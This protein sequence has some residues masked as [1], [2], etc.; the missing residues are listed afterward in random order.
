MDSH[1]SHL[2]IEALDL[3]KATDITVLSLIH[4]PRSDYSSEILVSMLQS[5]PIVMPKLSF[6]YW[7][8]PER[9]LSYNI[10]E[11]VGITYMKSM[12]RTNISSPV[13]KL[14]LPLWREYL[15]F[16][17]SEVTDRSAPNTVIDIYKTNREINKVNHNK[18]ID[19]SSTSGTTSTY[20][21][22]NDHPLN[23]IASAASAIEDK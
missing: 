4:I 16:V 10:A 9:L 18:S 7:Q 6:G 21:L 12:T 15:D 2:F 1:V 23:N 11:F 22:T 17:L 20:G 3:V 5:K 13:K 19:L 14:Y 8:T